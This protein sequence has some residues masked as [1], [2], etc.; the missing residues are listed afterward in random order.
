[1]TITITLLMII[2][3]LVLIVITGVMAVV[4]LFPVN[5]QPTSRA[6]WI[7]FVVGM[8]FVVDSLLI[9]Y[10]R[11]NFDMS[12]GDTVNIGKVIE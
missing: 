7:I 10:I 4:C 5:E 2:K 11:V 12:L 9:H 8:A 3:V 1:M 6:Q